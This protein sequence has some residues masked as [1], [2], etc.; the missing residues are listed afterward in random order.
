MPVT[1]SS[2]AADGKLTPPLY[3]LLHSTAVAHSRAQRRVANL[4]F[5]RNM[6]T[7]AHFVEA[8]LTVSY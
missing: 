5:A 7:C 6:E 8:I 2:L 3:L 4:Q 1:L